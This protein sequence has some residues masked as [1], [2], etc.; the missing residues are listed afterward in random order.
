MD[1]DNSQ[2]KLLDGSLEVIV[3]L[4]PDEFKKAKKQFLRYLS[5]T[6][7][8]HVVLRQDTTGGDMIYPY[9]KELVTGAIVYL[10]IDI[11]RCEETGS[12]Y[13]NIA[14]VA[15]HLAAAERTNSGAEFP[16]VSVLDQPATPPNRYTY[17]IVTFVG[18]A[19]T[20]G[21]ILMVVTKSNR[22]RARGAI[23][24]P[25]GFFTKYSANPQV[26]EPSHHKAPD[27][28]EM[29][30]FGHAPNPSLPELSITS[31]S[32]GDLK[33]WSDD[34]SDLP[35]SKRT[36][37]DS[38]LTE[39]DSRAQ[40][41]DNDNR[42]WT[43]QHLDAADI[44]NPDGIE[45]TPPQHE[46]E[47]LRTA[48]NGVDP[49]GPMGL[50]PLMIASFRGGGLEGY[51]DKENEDSSGAVIQELIEQGAELNA[52]MDRTGETSLHLAAR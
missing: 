32:C 18:L 51:S 5:N 21:I 49:K 46:Q 48:T 15:N 3:R 41:D 7:D 44:R 50:T 24:F 14:S 36:K 40:Y 26:P 10:E 22:K 25:E 45:L 30:N 9:S 31:N 6:L 52:T 11:R 39:P 4:S 42:Q 8:S 2:P 34:E 47:D 35:P 20:V 38:S 37:R 12:C 33:A 27:G 16:I 28:Q 17:V 1:C 29:Y 23:W 43:Q 19:I 13:E